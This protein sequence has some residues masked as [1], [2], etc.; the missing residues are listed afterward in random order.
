[1]RTVTARTSAAFAAFGIVASVGLMTLASAG[2]AQAASVLNGPID[3][4]TSSTYGV[5]AASEVTNTG[6]TTVVGDIGVD[7]GSSITGFGGAPDGS[8]TGEVHVSDAPALQAQSDLTTAYNDA[9]GLTPISTGLAELNGMSL[10]PGVYSGGELS[11]SDNGSLTLAGT[12]DSI[13]VFQAASSLTVGSATHINITGGASACNVFWQVGSSASIGTSAQFQGT[14]MADQSITAATGASVVGRLLAMNAAVTLQSNSI[15]VPA[16]CAP[17]N[18]PTATDDLKIS[19][20]TPPTAEV[21]TPYEFAVTATAPTTF[22]V[23]SGALPAGLGIDEAS[24]MITGTPTTPGVSSF[25]VT[26]TAGGLPDA[27][28][29]L[30]IAT[31]LRELAATGQVPLPGLVGGLALLTLGLALFA[32]RLRRA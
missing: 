25:V 27:T 13:W 26:A 32:F 14:V 10:A 29:S 11:I 21:G 8:N 7:P 1:M 22:R 23:T 4:G 28:A 5:L 24:G 16:D 19:S 12:A 9:A 31:R 30:T 3:L 18:P 2:P 6:T 15:T 20:G 17:G